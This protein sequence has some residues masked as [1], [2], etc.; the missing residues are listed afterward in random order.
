[1]SYVQVAMYSLI[2][3][4]TA[5]ELSIKDLG[6][7]YAA[8]FNTWK[9]WYDIGLMLNV[10]VHTLE[11]LKKKFKGQ[12]LLREALKSWL[13]EATKPTLEVLADAMASPC[14]A[15]QSLAKRIRRHIAHLKAVDLSLN[16]LGKVYE[17]VHEASTKWYKIGLM[18]DVP[19]VFLEE[20]R[21]DITVQEPLCGALKCWLNTA[22]KPTWKELVDVLKKRCVGE[23]RL[24]AQLEKKYMTIAY[25]QDISPPPTPTTTNFQ[26][27][28]NF[29]S[30][31]PETETFDSQEPNYHQTQVEKPISEEPQ[32]QVQ[33]DI[34]NAAYTALQTA[35]ATYK[36][37]LTCGGCFEAAYTHQSVSITVSSTCRSEKQRKS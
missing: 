29:P 19:V 36:W 34:R 23:A 27:F 3:F 1:M 18:L 31:S 14:V 32:V 10:P 7:I 22:Q 9:K 21:T 26:E 2:C 11:R 16:D 33:F 13:I 8:I 35:Y 5:T 6:I 20:I 4:P 15:E 12:E 17:A 24:A 25:T 30:L 37:L 28:Q